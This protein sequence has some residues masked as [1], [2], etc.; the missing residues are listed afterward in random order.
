MHEDLACK[1]RV[2]LKEGAM[3]DLTR[4]PSMMF[5]QNEVQTF[6]DNV[7]IYQASGVSRRWH[8]PGHNPDGPVIWKDRPWEHITY[9]TYS[10]YCVLRDPEDGLFKCWYEDLVLEPGQQKA[11][12][13]PHHSRQ[14][15][16]D[17]E[18]GID[19]RK[20]EIGI[21]EEVGTKTNIVLGSGAA[22]SDDVHSMSVVIDPHPPSEDQRFRALFT[23]RERGDDRRNKRI[24]CAHSADG[25]RWQLYAQSP[26]FG[27]SGA[28]LDD[29][30]V[31]FYDE[32]SREF[33]QNTRHFLKGPGG[34]GAPMGG[35]HHFASDS[36]RRVWQSRSHD[37]L[38][39]SEPI[40]VAAVGEEDGLDEEYYGMA[41]FRCGTVHLA[42]IGVFR[43]VDNE[44]DVQLLMSRDG[45]RWKPTAKRRPFLAPRGSGHYDTYMTA[46]VSAPIP[47]GDELWFYNGGSACH[48]D[49]WLWG[50]RDGVDHP[51][52][53]DPSCAELSL[54]LVRLRKDG[55]AGLYANPYREGWVETQSL[56]SEGTSLVVNAQCA[57]GGYVRVEARDRFGNTL[58][59][60]SR[61]NSDPLTGD[62]IDHTVTWKGDPSIPQEP[63]RRLAFF[64]KDAE[65]FSF[66]FA[67]GAT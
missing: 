21:V 45:L 32:D 67:G 27:R 28:R 3:R 12:A 8:R 44:R 59:R 51:E 24:V 42:T 6:L 34:A 5:V 63:W 52:A 11:S 25:I 40:L 13:V 57:D 58:G 56:M 26:R 60:C 10:N 33:V 50:R 4:D 55:Y 46:I 39:W 66:H 48:H 37:F 54:G 65:V 41:Q 30:S 38:H 15:Y 19:W 29:V 7:M 14:L 31:L 49:W 64:L 20:P 53:Y 16:A 43:R 2:V 61:E 9:F 23:Q 36:R 47:V 18:D 1:E 35:I 17:S 22:G 62:R